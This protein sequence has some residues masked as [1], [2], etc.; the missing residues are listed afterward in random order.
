MLIIIAYLRLSTCFVLIATKPTHVWVPL[1][2]I[3]TGLPTSHVL[4]HPE[5][6]TSTCLRLAIAREVFQSRGSPQ[7]IVLPR[8]HLVRC[9]AKTRNQLTPKHPGL[10]TR[11]GFL[12]FYWLV[13]R[14]RIENKCC[15]FVVH[16]FLRW[17][18]AGKSTTAQ[19]C[20]YSTWDFNLQRH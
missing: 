11:Y 10:V 12:D 4:F 17:Q 2:A 3:V 16:S 19:R 14:Q 1:M 18:I 8:V 5:P 9:A 20:G 13:V 7:E 15:V 6:S